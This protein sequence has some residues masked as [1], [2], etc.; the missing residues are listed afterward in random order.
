MGRDHGGRA[1]GISRDRPGA[2][3]D[4]HS[5]FHAY[6][7]SREVGDRAA[8]HPRRRRREARARRHRSPRQP[9]RR[10]RLR[11]QGDLPPWRVCRLRSAGRQQ[12]RAAGAARDGAARGRVRRPPDVLGG[13]VERLRENRDGVPAEAESRRRRRRG[14]APHHG[15]QP[16]AVSRVRAEAAAEGVARLR[17]PGI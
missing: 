8:R 16:A 2:C 12:R 7:N 4:Q 13:C 1:Q 11:A 5:H 15:R 6:G 10:E 3:G 14:A 9:R 17:L